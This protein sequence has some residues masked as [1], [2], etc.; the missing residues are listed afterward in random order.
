MSEVSSSDNS[1]KLSGESNGSR[2]RILV[3]NPTLQ[4]S[5]VKLDEKNYLSWSHSSSRLGA[6]M[7]ISL[8]IRE[9]QQRMII[10]FSHWDSKNSLVMSWLLNSLQ[11]NIA[12]GYKLLNSAYKI[13]YAVN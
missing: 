11:P 5:L 6:C 1:T 2:A 4:I 3:D 12:R 8:E 7:V 9:N 13:W 10:P